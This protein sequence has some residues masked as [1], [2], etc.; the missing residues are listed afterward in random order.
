M[1][2]EGVSNERDQEDESTRTKGLE[3][4]TMRN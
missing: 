3:G 2:P 4:M 1:D